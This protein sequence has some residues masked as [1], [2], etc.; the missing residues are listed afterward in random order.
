[1]LPAQRLL[2]GNSII[3]KRDLEGASDSDHC[4]G[5][6]FLLFNNEEYLPSRYRAG[7]VNIPFTEGNNCFSLYQT[8]RIKYWQKLTQVNSRAKG[9]TGQEKS[10]DSSG[11]HCNKR[12]ENVF[13]VFSEIT[14]R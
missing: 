8:S 13:R 5:K 4:W 12:N 10:H 11:N 7:E 6:K 3:V 1:M 14:K 9:A 2:A